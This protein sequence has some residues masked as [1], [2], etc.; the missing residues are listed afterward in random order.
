MYCVVYIMLWCISIL[1]IQSIVLPAICCDGMTI[2]RGR[3]L[4]L[5]AIKLCCYKKLILD[6]LFGNELHVVVERVE[7]K[8]EISGVK[9]HG[10]WAMVLHIFVSWR[11]LPLV[12]SID[13]AFEKSEWLAGRA[14]WWVHAGLTLCTK[15]RIHRLG[16]KHASFWCFCSP[17]TI[18]SSTFRIIFL[19]SSQ[20]IIFHWL[21]RTSHT[22][23][24]SKCSGRQP[25]TIHVYVYY[26]LCVHIILLRCFYLFLIFDVSE[27]WLLHAS[28]GLLVWCRP[29]R[30]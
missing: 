23:R 27:C 10:A 11:S 28:F 30:G 19:I 7:V 24:T 22:K 14:S 20:F 13:D 5:C 3:I 15:S 18:P 12:G 9:S 6:L 17:F 1:L 16:K 26:W 4:S 21:R 8:L 2:W 25:R 29:A